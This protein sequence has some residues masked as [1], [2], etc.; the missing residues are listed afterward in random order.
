MKQEEVES[1]S[2]AE[3]EFDNL[4]NPVKAGLP[5]DI[6]L[7]LSTPEASQPVVST[8]AYQGL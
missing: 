1:G 3:E 4:W 6:T 2:V 7:E 8:S 5:E